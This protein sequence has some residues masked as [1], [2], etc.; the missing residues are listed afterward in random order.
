MPPKR[1]Q[2]LSA[3][4]HQFLFVRSLKSSNTEHGTLVLAKRPTP[5]VLNMSLHCKSAWVSGST[6][7]IDMPRPVHEG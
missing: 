4:K 1:V 3:S 2:R 6:T 5:T 7:R